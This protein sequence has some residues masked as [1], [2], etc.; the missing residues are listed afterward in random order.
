M[1]NFIQFGETV[2]KIAKNSYKKHSF[3]KEWQ[4]FIFIA[5]LLKL[6]AMAFSIFAGFFYFDNLFISLLNSPFWSK[7]F[8]VLAL[9]F[10]EVLTAI[11]L[12]KFFKFAL[13][14]HFKTAVPVFFLSLFFFSISFISSTNGLALRQSSK[15]D[16][17]VLLTA[18][19]N[20][21]V[22]NINTLHSNQKDQAKEQ[23]VTIKANPQGWANGKRTILLAGQLNQ[24]DKYYSILQSLESVHKSELSKL[25]TSFNNSILQCE[26]QMLFEGEKYYKIVSFIMAL[27]FLVNGLIM[28][29]YSKV[30]NENEQELQKIEVIETFSDDI[31]NQTTGLIE[32]KINNTFDLYFSAMQ[33]SFDK[34]NQPIVKQGSAI[35][36]ANRNNDIVINDKK[37]LNKT[38]SLNESIN[39]LNCNKEF[40]PFNKIQKYCSTAC[41]ADYHKKKNGFD[42][43]L[44]KK[45]KASQKKS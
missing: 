35:G 7:F 41:R 39:C 9:L 10:I 13:R 38:Q 36:F 3:V 33:N 12:S 15:A 37:P 2:K 8:S 34:L 21:K 19:Y 45:F 32:D 14:L 30:F 42:M 11:S 5:I 1:R 18:Q 24:I 20:D 44:F 16:N 17:T 4:T 25:K 28:F 31:Q 27:V 26:R 22:F 43:V 6:A 23:I 40:K 29:F